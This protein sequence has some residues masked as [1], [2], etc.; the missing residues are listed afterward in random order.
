[1]SNA[2]SSKSGLFL[3]E[4]MAVI[5]FF[6]ISAAICLQMFVYASNTAENA[7]NLSYATLSARSVAECYQATDGDLGQMAEILSCFTQDDI[8]QI[9]YDAQ[10]QPTQE[11]P[12]F[13]LTL[14]QSSQSNPPATT[15]EIAVIQIGDA[16]V[17]YTLT[18]SHIISNLGGGLT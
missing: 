3:M 17:I 6:S 7:E 11:N 16:D 4:L 8:L 5:L 13:I 12:S 10:W 9:G 2:T 15:G 14:T 18:I 1:M